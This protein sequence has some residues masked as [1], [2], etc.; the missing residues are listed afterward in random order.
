[1]EKLKNGKYMVGDCEKTM[2]L[3]QE[4]FDDIKCSLRKEEA[5]SFI[6]RFIK[7]SLPLYENVNDII[8]KCISYYDIH[9]DETLD[10]SFLDAMK[11]CI[12]ETL[13]NIEIYKAEIS[14]DFYADIV[15][16]SYEDAEKKAGD[17]WGGFLW[18]NTPRKLNLKDLPLLN[19]IENL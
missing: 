16:D 10:V 6:P 19:L 4:A 18:I 12:K 15:A 17:K 2:I 7:A 3:S 9:A 8:E 5:K 1:M 13:R 11:K 14:E